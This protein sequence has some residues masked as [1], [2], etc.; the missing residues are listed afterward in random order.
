PQNAL[1]PGNLGEEGSA[2]GTTAASM[3]FT[4]RE[5]QVHQILIRSWSF[6]LRAEGLS[7][8]T[9]AN[10]ESAVNRF[11]EWLEAELG[12]GL[13]TATIHDARAFIA[14]RGEQSP[15]V[16]NMAWRALRSF[17]RWAEAEGESENIADR[18]CGLWV[19]ERWIRLDTSS[20]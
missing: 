6:A 4:L 17:Y 3:T 16:A 8:R 2:L 5:S 15:F 12:R 7:P 1:S 19:G 11:A 10:Y 18:I 20:Q 14:H 13:T 9:V